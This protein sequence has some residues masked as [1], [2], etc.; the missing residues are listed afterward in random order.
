MQLSV[1]P[2]LRLS[3]ELIAATTCSILIDRSM[4]KHRFSDL[5]PTMVANQT[6]NNILDQ[7]QNSKLNFQLQI[8]PF[9]AN[10]SLKKTLIKDKS[11]TPVLPTTSSGHSRD[12]LEEIA[13]LVKKN[14][15]LERELWSLRLDHENA[16]EDC[17]EANLKIKYLE[18]QSAVKLECQEALQK[19]LFEKDETLNSLR[20]EI[21]QLTKEKYDQGNT[22]RNQNREIKDLEI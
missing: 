10:I 1:N 14:L 4:D 5:N 17:R 19:E 22:I 8:S 16:I 13:T 7:I 15:Q 11:G 9:S 3:S 21:H 2:K 12:S 20:L 18:A 6:F